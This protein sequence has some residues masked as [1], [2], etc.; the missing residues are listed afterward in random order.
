LAR[1]PVGLVHAVRDEAVAFF[2]A[3]ESV[4]PQA[5]TA[6][7]GWTAHEV[8]AH[9]ASGAD[10]LANQIE[11]HLEHKSIP[12]FGSWEQREPRYRAIEDDRL[13]GRLVQ[14]EQRMSACFDE[15]L[16]ASAETVI[17]QVGFG[18]PVGELVLHMR[19][20]FAV[21]LWDLVGDN[22]ETAALLGQPELLGHSVRMLSRPLL[23][24]GL[25]RDPNPKAPLSVRVRCD[26]HPDLQVTVQD[27]AGQIGLVLPAE[28]AEMTAADP[29][30]RLLLVWGRRV[31]D[32]RRM[33]SNLP[34]DV[35]LRVQTILAG[36]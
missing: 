13:R 20:E 19:Q 33:R 24:N 32:S 9:L 21:H 8:I 23:A 25:Q 10:A 5:V 18:F 28:P 6:C 30:A 3:L 15:L 26:G 4:P 31:P 12:E 22:A 29:A 35:L 11:A 34:L 7:R 36:Y 14:A 17:E 27:G 16:K 2:A 1:D